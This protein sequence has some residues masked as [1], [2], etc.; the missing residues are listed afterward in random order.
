MAVRCEEMEFSLDGEEEEERVENVTTFWYL[1]IPLEQTYDD[2]PDV[3][4][5]IMRA[6]SV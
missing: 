4:R 6:R 1:R 2:W 3:R 5:N